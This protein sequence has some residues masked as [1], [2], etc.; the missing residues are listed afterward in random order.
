MVEDRIGAGRE[1][2]A[3]GAW[4]QAR[5]CFEEALRQEESAE[6]W[7]GLSWACWWMDDGDG[8]LDAREHAYRL[9]REAGDRR[10]A[11][12]LAIWLGND[13]VEFRGALAVGG[14]W[15]E[16]ARRL[17]DELEP[18]PEHGWLAVIE[19]FDTLEGGDT[20]GAR[21]LA[22]RGR[23]LGR[24]LGV[25]GLEMFGLATEGL[26]LVSEGEVDR[27]MRCLDE[28]SAAAL[29]GEFEDLAPAGWTCCY[30]I[31]ACERVRDYDR[32]AQWCQ[33]VEQFAAR[34][35]IRFLNGTCRAHY[36]GVLTWHGRWAEAG[37]ELAEAIGSLAATRP[38][39]T[40]EGV[41]RLA[42]LRRRQGR[43]DEARDL[44]AQAGG[45]PLAAVGMGE[46]ALDTGDLE[47]AADLAEQVLRELPAENR[48][49]RAG[50]L[51]LMARV[52]AAQGD[53][54]AARPAATEL[55]AIAGA[56]GTGPLRAA[57]SL[58]EGLAAEPGDARR[59]L[60]DAV[61][62]YR[63]G[64][65]PYETARAR[66]ELARVLALL[67]R[68]QAAARE[69]GAALDA[70]LALGAAGEAARA[71]ALLRGLR[72]DGAPLTPRELEV[73]QLVAGGH[74][75]RAIAAELTISEHTVHRHVANIYVKLRCSTRAAAV[76]E[77][78]RL[79]L[80]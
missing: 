31:Y 64:D 42:E 14:G 33:E 17:L 53:R 68:P 80:L 40:A 52:R 50:A 15:L 73:L 10:G 8:A 57:A 23:E 6:G 27:G 38:F 3:G 55:R 44:F 2:L 39:W 46:L 70:L 28:A 71:R 36:A 69:A 58:A 5:A 22:G 21:E 29:A 25:V 34:R 7:E 75:D 59:R 56:V 66:I 49:R 67:N 62:L 79:D 24:R 72:A 65:A 48:T 1:A 43:V 74:G 35:R 54:D 37:A 45:H 32:A 51:E 47:R 76:A 12:R 20:A 13:H 9:Y 77:A 4:E 60:E 19:A 11:A 16:R 18:A 30:L 78:G 26:A 63:R 41:V 61:E